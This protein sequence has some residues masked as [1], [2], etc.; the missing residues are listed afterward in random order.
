MGYTP[1]STYNNKLETGTERF[2]REVQSI[3]QKSTTKNKTKAVI[4]ITFRGNGPKFVAVLINKDEP[5]RKVF[6]TYNRKYC[7]T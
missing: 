7:Y 1:T 2:S 6:R 3:R 4:T 5:K